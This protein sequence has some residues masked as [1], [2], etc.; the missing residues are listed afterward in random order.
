[1]RAKSASGELTKTIYEKMIMLANIDLNNN[2]SDND[3]TIDESKEEEYQFSL[4]TGSDRKANEED[5][6]T[7]M[8]MA[9]DKPMFTVV[10]LLNDRLKGYFV[11]DNV[12]YLSYRKLSEAD[13]SLL[14]KGFRFCPA[15]NTIHKSILES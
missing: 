5:S 8:E 1:M 14:S 11:S 12:F 13:V 7:F 3:S 6:N 9:S 15:P 2:V 10:E 4:N